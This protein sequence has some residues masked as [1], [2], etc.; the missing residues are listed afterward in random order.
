VKAWLVLCL[1]SAAWG[2][3]PCERSDKKPCEFDAVRAAKLYYYAS[4]QVAREINPD[5]PPKLLPK[6]SLLLGAKDNGVL[7]NVSECQIRLTK[8]DE[9]MFAQGVAFAAATQQLSAE[10]VMKAAR[11][12]VIFLN[13]TVDK[14]SLRGEKKR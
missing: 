11:T 1:I 4:A 12:A 13:A 9:E 3:I 7:W 6:I 14:D 2:Q 8:W 10:Q 5:R